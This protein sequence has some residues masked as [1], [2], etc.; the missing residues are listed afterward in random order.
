MCPHPWPSQVV[1]FV[2]LLTLGDLLYNPRL[3]AYAHAHA[4]P[5]P[6]LSLSSPSPLPLLSRYSLV[7]LSRSPRGRLCAPS[8]V[9]PWPSLL[10]APKVPSPAS[11]PPSLSSPSCQLASWEA[12]SS[13][14]IARDLPAVTL[15]GS[16]D[17]WAPSQPSRLYCCGAALPCCASRPRTS[18]GGPTTPS[19]WGSSAGVAAAMGWWQAAAA[20][21][22]RGGPPPSSVRFRPPRAKARKSTVTVSQTLPRCDVRR[23]SVIG[24]NYDGGNRSRRECKQIF[25]RRR[26]NHP[27]INP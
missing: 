25:R 16:L 21:A 15:R 24:V 17:R 26:T 2:L 10:S 12:S 27:L 8:A 5:W 11:R 3:N 22:R 6:L 1:C 13:I 14:S 20:Y 18:L 19:A 4:H 9:M 23:R 7:V